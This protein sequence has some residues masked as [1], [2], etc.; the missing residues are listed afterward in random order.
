MHLDFSKNLFL[1]KNPLLLENLMT[2]TCLQTH[3]LR[4]LGLKSLENYSCCM[5][6]YVK[7]YWNRLIWCLSCMWCFNKIICSLQKLFI[8]EIWTRF[9]TSFDVFFILSTSNQCKILKKIQFST[10]KT[11]V[12]QFDFN[13]SISS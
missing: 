5:K 7:L 2:W 9:V 4:C 8:S 3:Y 6:F 11:W 13:G 12:F 1:L 10:V